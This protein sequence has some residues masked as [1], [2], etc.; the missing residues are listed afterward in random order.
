MNH[1]WSATKQ[2]LHPQSVAEISR[3]SVLSADRIR[4]C[5]TSSGSRHKYSLSR[6]FLLQAPQC[7]CS[8]QKR[9]SRDHCCRERSRPGCRIV[10]LHTRWELTTWADFQLGPC[11]HRLLMSTDCKSSHNGFLDVSRSNGGLTISGWIGELS[12]LTIFS[13]S[14]SVW[15]PSHLGIKGNERV[16]RLEQNVT[17]KRLL[18]ISIKRFWK[19]IS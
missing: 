1:N 10:G 15:I 12:C 5:E 6:H 4:Q 11:L 14:L 18:K 3:H 8:V 16:D 7:P 13:T 17:K 2:P 19:I 9:F